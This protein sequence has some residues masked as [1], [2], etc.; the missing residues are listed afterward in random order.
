MSKKF[1]PYC[2]NEVVKSENE[3]YSWQ[4]LE[5][6]EDFYDFEV[7]D[8]KER[9]KKEKPSEIKVIVCQPHNKAFITTL[10]NTLEAKQKVVEGWIE[11]IYPWEDKV[12]LVCNEEGKY[13]GSE[14]NR[15]LYDEDGNMIDII[16][17][18]FFICGLTDEDFGSLSDELA[19][20]YM[21]KFLYPEIFIR[22]R[23]GIQ[24]IK[25]Q[26]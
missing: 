10:S 25:I 12:A 19:E 1:C 2:Y 9:E 16:A 23:K 21:K 4:C 13:N 15:A 17:G 22:T 26:D 6:E 14:L 18:T 3:E 8:E 5:C 7:V 24:A 11:A 20:K